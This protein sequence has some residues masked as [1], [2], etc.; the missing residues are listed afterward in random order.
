MDHNHLHSNRLH[1]VQLA[2]LAYQA[3]LKS[4]LSSLLTHGLF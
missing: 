3:F 1:Q 4:L 2:F